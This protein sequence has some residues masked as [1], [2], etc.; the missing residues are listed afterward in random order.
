VESLGHGIYK[1]LHGPKKLKKNMRRNMKIPRKK[2]TEQPVIVSSQDYQ[3]D[4]NSLK[5][6]K[7]K[8]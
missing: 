6:I 7:Q 8:N 5:V 3:P 1:K 2:K 4:M